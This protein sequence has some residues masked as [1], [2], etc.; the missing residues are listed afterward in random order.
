M[1]VLMI[2]AS[3]MNSVCSARVNTLPFVAGSPVQFEVSSGLVLA[4][5]GHQIQ[6]DH[7]LGTELKSFLAPALPLVLRDRVHVTEP[8]SQ[9]SAPLL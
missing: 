5:F 1:S 6:V 8:D 9:C 3:E 7:L 2:W 4:L